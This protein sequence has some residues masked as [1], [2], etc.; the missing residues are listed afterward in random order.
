[1]AALGQARGRAACGVRLVDGARAARRDRRGCRPGLPPC[2]ASRRDHRRPARA[3]AARAL[4]RRSGRRLERAVRRTRRGGRGVPAGE[5]RERRAARRRRPAAAR[6]VG[7][8]GDRRC[9]SAGATP[10]RSSGSRR[11][12]PWSCPPVL[13]LG[14][15]RVLTG[16]TLWSQHVLDRYDA[17]F[18]PPHIS[19]GDLASTLADRVDPTLG[20]PLLVLALAA[21]RRQPPAPSVR[22]GGRLHAR[23]DRASGRPGRA[24]RGHE[25]RPRPHADRARPARHGRRSGAARGAAG[26]PRA[27]ARGDPLSRVRGGARCATRSAASIGS[28]TRRRSSSTASVPH[29]GRARRG[30]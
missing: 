2:R 1:M 26:P 22:A 30:G 23:A 10:S 28:R 8:R 17:R 14:L 11:S 3:R 21:P 9:S 20:W 15:D 18:H 16:D 5:L 25:R 19:Y 4:A 7:P 24:R 12:P 27:R 6:G 29:C 13:W